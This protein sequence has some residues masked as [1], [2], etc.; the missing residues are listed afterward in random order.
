MDLAYDIIKKKDLERSHCENMSINKKMCTIFLEFSKLD[1]LN[2]SNE[3]SF[4]NYINKINTYDFINTS[5]ALVVYLFDNPSADLGYS[6]LEAYYISKHGVAL[7]TDLDDNI[8]RKIIHSA[9]K[10]VLCLEK[11]KTNSKIDDKFYEIID[12]YYS[13]YKI[14]KSLDKFKLIE[15]MYNEFVNNV[16]IYNNIITKPDHINA[17][18]KIENRI[19]VLLD[20]IVTINSNY[21]IKKFLENYKILENLIMI[22]NRI[23]FYIYNKLMH[24]DLQIIIILITEIKNKLIEKSGI[25]SRRELYYKIDTYDIVNCIR[26]NTL[27]P[28]VINKV[29]HI[30]CEKAMEITSENF[31]DIV[32]DDKWSHIYNKQ[33]IRCFKKLYNLANYD[34]TE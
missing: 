20:K 1:L 4:S 17:S 33:L 28:V 9:N 22:R 14:W 16:Q 26:S 30:L 23:W 13:V 5:N 12:D 29:I 6:L 25:K 11:L 2:L 8:N 27:M 34:K 10:V 24:N 19:I 32:M 18:I 3:L 7:I 31:D 21:G 15:E